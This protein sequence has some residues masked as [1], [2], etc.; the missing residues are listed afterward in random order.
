MVAL[1]NEIAEQQKIIDKI[2][3]TVDG[4][5][6]VVGMDVFYRVMDGFVRKNV[7]RIIINLDFPE[8]FLTL[9]PTNGE[10]RSTNVCY[11]INPMQFEK[12]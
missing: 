5:P 11:G 8:A 9:H 12:Q 7:Y 2:P 3:K 1:L 6:V 4:V 10:G